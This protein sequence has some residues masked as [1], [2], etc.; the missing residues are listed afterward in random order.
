[1]LK[2]IFLDAFDL[3]NSKGN[4]IREEEWE[5]TVEDGEK[6]RKRADRLGRSLG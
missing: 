3:S 2:E 5:F 4:R 1:M 6:V